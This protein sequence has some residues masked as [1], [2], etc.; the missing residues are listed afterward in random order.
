MFTQY[1]YAICHCECSC[2]LTTVAT[3]TDDCISKDRDSPD[4]AGED[5]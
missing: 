1:N 2:V 4:N 3:G 5:S